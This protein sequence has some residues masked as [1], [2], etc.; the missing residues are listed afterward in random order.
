M[1]TFDTKPSTRPQKKCIARYELLETN[2]RVTMAVHGA[3]SVRTQFHNMPLKLSPSPGIRSLFIFEH[4]YSN[5][6]TTKNE[7]HEV[8]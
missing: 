2:N 6:S 4:S 5:Y 8:H 7:I 1:P 3:S